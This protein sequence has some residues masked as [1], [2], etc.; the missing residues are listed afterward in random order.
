MQAIVTKYHGPTNS[1]GGRISATAEAGRIYVEWDHALGIDENH[2]AAAM[3][4]ARKFD[5]RGLLYRGGL[6][7]NMGGNVYVF[8]PDAR[9][10]DKR[11]AAT[12]RA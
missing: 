7:R 11:P 6:P 4:F 2:D 9:P 10:F 12:V 8:A 5:W 1:K 3:A